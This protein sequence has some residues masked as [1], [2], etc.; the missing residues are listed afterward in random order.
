VQ[1]GWREEAVQCEWRERERE[2]ERE[3]GQCGC[4]STWG[5]KERADRAAA[6]IVVGKGLDAGRFAGCPGAGQVCSG[7]ILRGLQRVAA[8]RRPAKDRGDSQT[9]RES[10]EV[11]QAEKRSTAGFMRK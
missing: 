4:G 9:Q 6:N 11:A 10:R 3:S 8:R 5:A 7:G 1:C 2:R